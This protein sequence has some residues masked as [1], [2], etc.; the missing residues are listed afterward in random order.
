MF[1]FELLPKLKNN[2]KNLYTIVDN[3]WLS[4]VIFN[5]FNYS[6]DVVVGS[7]TKYV[8]GGTAIGGIV[9]MNETN[10]KCGSSYLI[11][12]SCLN[13]SHLSPHNAKI[14]LFSI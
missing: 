2:H 13:G 5:P 3:T 6:V 12:W 9:L 8:S 10:T 7:L 1:D 4:I 11:E 14:I